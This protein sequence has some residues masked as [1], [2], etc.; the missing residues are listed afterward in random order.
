MSGTNNQGNNQTIDDSDTIKGEFRADITRDTFDPSKNYTRVIMQQG[1]VQLDADWNEQ[2]DILLYYLRA[3]AVDLIGPF[4]GL[5]PNAGFNITLISPKDKEIVNLCISKGR[6]YVYGILCENKEPVTYFKN[7]TD[8]SMEQP[9][10]SPDI[11]KTLK[12]PFFVYLDVWERTITC[13][14]D[15]NIREIALN[16][17]DTTIRSQLIWQVK[18][19]LQDDY[20]K[21]VKYNPD[22]QFSF[23]DILS[24]EQDCRW[25]KNNLQ[26]WDKVKQI[27]RP[28]STGQLTADAL[29]SADDTDPCIIKPEARYRGVENQLY[30]VEISTPG[31]AN[32]ATYK[33]AK[34]NTSVNFPIVSLTSTSATLANLGRDDRTTL[35]I[36]DWVEII[37]DYHVL[38]EEP[39]DLV[40]II[41][42]DRSTMTV[43]FSNPLNP[44]SF[45]PDIYQNN[46]N[47]HMRRW[48]HKLPDNIDGA[49]T[50]KE[51]CFL[52]LENGVQIQFQDG[53]Y[54]NTC[55]YW[56]LPVRAVTGDVI[57]PYTDETKT[58]RKP[59]LPHG[60]KHHYAPLAAVAVVDNKDDIIIKDFRCIYQIPEFNNKN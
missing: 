43:T 4:G 17:P 32:Q 5:A 24:T 56:L 40:Q 21:I 12:L 9:Y 38:S 41:S 34:G 19:L 45:K 15:S 59:L 3:L 31:N 47:L 55:D 6:Y 26:L 27:I 16:G 14:E 29:K 2:A 44:S 53:G 18:I 58:K 35:S 60:I 46:A 50:I 11:Y 48:D 23:D 7:K 1:R 54:Y 57:W 51:G 42:V 30:R 10:Y 25:F 39:G 20:N 49:M 28:L 52:D 36:D 8:N 33:W 22:I 37:D 13:N